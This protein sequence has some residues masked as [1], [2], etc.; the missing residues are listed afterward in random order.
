MQFDERHRLGLPREIAPKGPV[1]GERDAY[2]RRGR[3]E[4]GSHERL[5]GVPRADQARWTR[6]V[7]LML[8]SVSAIVR[9]PSP[10]GERRAAEEEP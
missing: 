2:C 1:I 10:S 4:E 8:T 3:E 6:A 7:L 9:H 5:G